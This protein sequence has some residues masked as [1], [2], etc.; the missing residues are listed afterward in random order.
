MRYPLL[1]LLFIS[2]LNVSS[3]SDA[4]AQPRNLDE[5]HAA[6]R[7]LLDDKTLREIEAG[8][9]EETGRFHHGLG[10]TLR[11][12]WGLWRGGPLRD[13]FRALGFTHPD[14]MS[15]TILETFWCRLHGKPFRLKERAQ[16]YREYWAAM[17]KPSANSPR[18]NS[19]IDWRTILMRPGPSAIHI[20]ISR[21]DGSCWRFELKS[22]RGVEPA[23]PDEIETGCR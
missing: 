22:G 1:S 4:A 9:E 12:E 14:D 3:A 10:T 21:S 2:I 16:Y 13:Y 23:R 6:L 5:A 15:G 18:D 8:T 19:P 7:S 17:K 11:N 20:G